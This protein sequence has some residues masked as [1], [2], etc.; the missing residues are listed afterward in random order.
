[1]NK[2]MAATS[3]TESTAGTKLEG[4]WDP[5]ETW[6]TAYG[7]DNS[8]NRRRTL[9]DIG[10]HLTERMVDS[11]KRTGGNVDIGYSNP[12][13][14]GTPGSVKGP[15]GI[16]GANF[17]SERTAH[18]GYA[19]NVL[20]DA[21]TSIFEFISPELAAIM[22]DKRPGADVDYAQ[23]GIAMG[24]SFVLNPDFQFNELDDVRSDYRRPYIGRLYS[25]RIYD[26]NLPKVI[27]EVGTLTL[28]L[29][30]FTQIGGLLG[31]GDGGASMSSYLRDP[32]NNKMNFG[33]Q[34]VGAAIRG[35]L[36][37]L[38]G[39]LF[40]G[41]RLYKF[42]SNARIYSR[43]VNE[44]LIE[45]ASWMNLASLPVIDGANGYGGDI[46]DNGYT[47][48]NDKNIENMIKAPFGNNAKIFD[49]LFKLTGT[50][51]YAGLAQSLSVL[52][53]LPKYST[54]GRVTKS[55][56]AQHNDVASSIV[57][58]VEKF[59]DDAANLYVP[60]ALHKGVSVSETFST[61]T[62]EHPM[63]AELNS[64]GMQ[65]EQTTL[66]GLLGLDFKSV[67]N[68]FDK[69]HVGQSIASMGG[70]M[71]TQMAKTWLKSNALAAGGEMAL[72]LSGNARFSLPEI[73]QDSSFERSYNLDFKFKSPYG[74]RL[75]IFENTLVPLLFLIGMTAPRQVGSSAYM[76]P[77]YIRA[78]SKGLFS[79][80]L[81]M[82]SSL[83]ITRGEDRNDRTAEGF[84]R[85]I[86]VT[87]SIKD[88]VPKLMMGM[89]A[90]VF[91]ILSS[92]NVGF[93]EYMA[94]LAG[95]DMLDRAALTKKFGVFMNVLKNRFN[96]DGIMNWFRMTAAS[97]PPVKLIA[98]A[99]TYFYGTEV[100]TNKSQLKA[101]PV[102]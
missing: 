62:Q 11:I 32:A 14:L 75:A 73:W 1:V 19:G 90:G 57:D 16:S 34:H 21:A 27:F 78:F 55:N 38:G 22:G 51:S 63:A 53:V 89:D 5:D 56:T 102:F 45:L 47:G 92:K 50:D 74:H 67:G 29:G 77:F 95:V 86:S 87:M 37:F 76:S 2:D 83:G 52:N 20:Q 96:P 13:I 23:P 80:E 43:F 72:V 41:S 40:G 49:S 24:D 61:R 97:F 31:N 25:E 39:G 54:K 84:T 17:Y 79:C 58:F 7:Y 15:N 60:F 99:R 30:L 48:D 101:P 70:D 81:G 12:P 82:V 46:Y 85:T 71:A 69:D 10:M 6:K 64:K 3:S 59:V 4:G 44:M 68:K 100:P 65:T 66:M 91:G 36:N 42:T 98:Q 28:N 33:F 26:Y 9:D 35:V 93:R 18:G 94:L 8:Y 88:V